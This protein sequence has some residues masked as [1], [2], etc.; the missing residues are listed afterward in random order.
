[1][2]RPKL[3]I[4][5][6]FSGQ[7]GVERMIANLCQALVNAPIDL[8]VLLI[9][10]QG[11]YVDSLPDSAN[12]ISL[13]ARHSLTSVWEVARYLKRERPDALLAIKHRGIL[14][15][16]R[17]RQL[18][19]ADTPIS[20][21][22][23]T[24]VSAA[25]AN[26]SS[27]RRQRWYRAMRKH[28]PK[29]EKLIAVSQGVAEDVLDITGMNESRVT[30]VRNPTITPDMFAAAN[31]PVEHPWLSPDNL[32]PVIMGVG[33]LTEQKDFATLIAAFAKVR[34]QQEAR[35]IILGDG[36]LR[37]ELMAQA[38][39]LGVDEHIALP[40]F[41]SNPWAWMS[42]AAVFALSSRWEG[43]PNTLTEAMALGIPVVS[44]DCPSGPRELLDAG[45]VAPLVAMGDSDTLANALLSVL[46]K[47]PQSQML[48]EA[49]ST[50]HRDVSAAAYLQ[51]LGL[52][53]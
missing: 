18:A 37:S 30:V 35:L 39:A 29:L 3:A 43:S 27:R 22:I 4:L 51:A 40:G 21:R 49:V 11:P 5:V 53:A 44:T 50:Y 13:R 25:L 41:Q 2:T 45:R 48:T 12:I 28:Y 31:E 33:R 47:P 42:R 36:G 34:S 8:D 19:R 6:S 10:A 9:K 16:L 1:V 7:G 46:A 24:T 14:A 23:G 32:V 15:A 38:T 52:S 26:K 17:A 20:G